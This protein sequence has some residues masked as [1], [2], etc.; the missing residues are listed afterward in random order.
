MTWIYCWVVTS[1]DHDGD[2][3]WIKKTLDA[4]PKA[5]LGHSTNFSDACNYQDKR[6][7]R[8]LNQIY[9]QPIDINFSNLFMTLLKL[10][11]ERLHPKLQL[12]RKNIFLVRTS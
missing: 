8:A 11:R 10:K 12:T 2:A 1:I 7:S 3:V 9:H 6:S 5:V 4:E